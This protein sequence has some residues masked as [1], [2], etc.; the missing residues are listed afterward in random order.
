ML[1]FFEK[2]KY[3]LLPTLLT[4]F[5]LLVLCFPFAVNMTYAQRE[6]SPT[7]SLTYTKGHLKWDSATDINNNGIATLH[8]FDAQ[9]ENVSSLDK[10][11]VVAPGT[12]GYHFIRLN[13]KSSNEISY[14]AVLYKITSSNKL[15]VQV[16]LQDGEYENTTSTGLPNDIKNKEVVRSVK[17]TVTQN[18][19][20]DF[21]IMWLWDYEKSETQNLIDTYLGNQSAQNHAEDITV[22][23]YIV[24]E[25]QNHSY[26]PSV[27]K[28]GDHS[29]IGGYSSLMI[30]S[31]ILFI[32]LL[33]HRKKDEEK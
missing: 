4:F 6:N 32:I 30:I 7:H 13:N 12:K 27:P 3:W 23:F 14:T 22:G 10:R 18:Q 29:I 2:Q 19:R 17:G 24:I 25:D 8:L 16:T 31:M 9:Y 33:F 15:P 5:I 11:V 28:T 20:V 1:R 21:D 26:N